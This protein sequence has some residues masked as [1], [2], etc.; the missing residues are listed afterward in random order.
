MPESQRPVVL[1]R[2]SLLPVCATKRHRVPATSAFAPELTAALGFRRSSPA[3]D[4]RRFDLEVGRI[5]AAAA[6]AANKLRL[7]TTAVAAFS[8]S[9]YPLPGFASVLNYSG[10]SP[11]QIAARFIILYG[12]YPDLPEVI[13][14]G[15]ALDDPPRQKTKVQR[16]CSTGRS[17]LPSPDCID[18][19]RS[20]SP[21]GFRA[22]DRAYYGPRWATVTVRPSPPFITK[23][24]WPE[25]RLKRVRKLPEEPRVLRDPSGCADR[26][27]ETACQYREY[28]STK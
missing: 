18:R 28:W 15:T 7:R 1:L 27:T 3:D 2:D 14:L 20:L 25:R 24:S 21:G 26:R 8:T 16:W 23:H 17:W 10:G 11:S 13:S 22:L 12:G 19:R 5:A 6:G 9:G 4:Q